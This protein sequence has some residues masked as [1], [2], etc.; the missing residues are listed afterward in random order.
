MTLQPTYACY[1]WFRLIEVLDISQFQNIDFRYLPQME[2]LLYA[3][4]LVF[5]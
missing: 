1:V 2:C 5:G 4:I 3:L